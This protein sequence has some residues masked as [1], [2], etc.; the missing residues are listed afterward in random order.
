MK[1]GKNWSIMLLACLLKIQCSMLER[2]NVN[3][4]RKESF[5]GDT[6][7]LKMAAIDLDELNR[8]I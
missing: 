2:S 7:M 1:T 5:L 4:G 3:L 6:E 8:L